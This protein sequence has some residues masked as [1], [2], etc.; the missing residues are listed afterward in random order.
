MVTQY[1]KDYIRTTLTICNLMIGT[2]LLALPYTYMRL[3]WPVASIVTIFSVV[4]SIFG[5]NYVID[6]CYYTSCQTL[7]DLLTQLFGKVISI[8]IEAFI[9]F[10]YFGYLISYVSICAD[11][12]QIF[13]VSISNYS[14][15]TI[16][17][18]IIIFGMLTFFLIFKTLKSISNL[19]AAQQLFV[20]IAVVCVVVFYGIAVQAGETLI[21]INGT[22][23]TIKLSNKGLLAKPVH[24]RGIY[25]FLE[26]I[27]RI[28]L[29]LPL[30]GCQ[31]SVPVVFNVMPGDGDYR[32][33][34]LKKAM[35]TAT[36]VTCT[37]C[38]FMAFFCLFLFGRDISTNVLLSF[39]SQNYVMTTVRF[40]YALVVL[41][42]YVVVTFPIR[43]MFMKIF[44]QD[45]N[46]NKGYL[47][48]VILGGAMAFLSCGFSILVPDIL[49]VFNI[50]SSVFGFIENWI[51]PILFLYK[52]EDMKIAY[53]QRICKE[54][55]EG[56]TVSGNVDKMELEEI[57]QE[58]P[59]QIKKKL[60]IKNLVF[61]LTGCFFIVLLNGASFILSTFFDMASTKFITK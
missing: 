34:V 17:L 2:S 18:K 56:L 29:F 5:F 21:N 46:T 20:V 26:I 54:Y 61:L 53:E 32:R 12:T 27:Q 11:Y 47:I 13:I 9:V 15:S 41:L 22:Q 37:L 44:K 39:V 3:G 43:G 36:L 1:Q 30:F 10:Q 59:Q 24:T 40:L 55:S 51:L 58:A 8:I 42:T 35:I 49:K 7:S 28:P 23:S 16:Y 48:Y 33:G 38:V 45:K 6:A 60:N 50:V 25:I 19:S 52:H 14:F 57:M 4:Y 31:A